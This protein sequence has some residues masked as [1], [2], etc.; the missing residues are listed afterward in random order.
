MNI[1]LYLYQ[2]PGLSSV[3]DI[4]LY[5]HTLIHTYTHTRIQAISAAC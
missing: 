4:Y 1:Y 3:T 2:E 5:T